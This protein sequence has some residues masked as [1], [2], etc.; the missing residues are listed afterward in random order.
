M[1][2]TIPVTYTFS[3]HF[4]V[5]ANSAFE[6]QQ[7]V[8]NGC[9]CVLRQGIQSTLPD[10]LIDWNFAIHPTNVEIGTAE[11]EEEEPE[12]NKLTEIA[13]LI[14]E[15]CSSGSSP[16]WTLLIDSQSILDFEDLDTIANMVEQ[17]LT[18]GQYEA[19]FSTVYWS[20]EIQ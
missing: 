15:G 17:G 8:K 3:G 16:D 12:D 13:R 11:C 6:A 9:G 19:G 4:E 1:K 7:M 20:I 5:E 14:R 10:E 18:L 2:Y